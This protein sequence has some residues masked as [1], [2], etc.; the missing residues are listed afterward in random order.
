[1]EMSHGF[2]D[3][4]RASRPDPRDLWSILFASFASVARAQVDCG[5][6][7]HVNVLVA[8]TDN[9]PMPKIGSDK[10]IALNPKAFF[11]RS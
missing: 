9:V 2:R 5:L 7:A 4:H 8:R 10:L 6:G 1:M 3:R 11:S